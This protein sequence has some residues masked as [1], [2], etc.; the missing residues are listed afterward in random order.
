MID[1]CWVKPSSCNAPACRGVFRPPSARR[2]LPS[3]TMATDPMVVEGPSPRLYRSPSQGSQ[4]AIEVCVTENSRG[5]V[6]HP[7]VAL[8]MVSLPSSMSTGSSPE[9]SYAAHLSTRPL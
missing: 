8:V 7:A 9:L 2:P 3:L 5:G 6:R 4:G 1:H